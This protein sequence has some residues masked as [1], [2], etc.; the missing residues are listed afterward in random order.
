MSE[1]SNPVMAPLH[2]EWTERL[3]VGVADIDEQHRELYRRIDLFLTALAKR[4]GRDEL[5]PLVTYLEQYI[6]EH[7]ATE[8]QLMQLSGYPY[9]GDHMIAHHWFEDEYRRLVDRLDLE[10]VTLGVARDLVG[11]LVG[12]LDSHLEL[13][14]HQFGAYLARYRLGRSPPSA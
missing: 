6:G 9:L 11:L 7:F 5:G 14:D 2:V 8:Q 3:S 13:T 12:W 1:T 10:G 4:R